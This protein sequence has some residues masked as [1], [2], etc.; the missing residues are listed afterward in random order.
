MLDTREADTMEIAELVRA[1][2][3]GR[4][5]QLIDVRST[6]EF[7]AGHLPGA[8]SIPMAEIESRLPDLA[9]DA[10]IV[11]VCQSG[12]R[13]TMVAERLAAR[14]VDAQ[15]L[16]GGT[17]AWMSAGHDV[18]ASVNTRWSLERQVRFGAGLLVLTGVALA[19]AVDTQWTFLAAFAGAGLTFSGVTDI[20]LLGALLARM[21][22]NRPVAS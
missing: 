6:M 5:L 22:W 17:T 18:V 8:I 19:M 16:A 4:A 14:G 10:P 15:V 7:R 9:A 11:L 21:P 13:A 20:C 12:R 3:S 2:T 1:K